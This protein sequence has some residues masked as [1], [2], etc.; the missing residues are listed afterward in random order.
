MSVSSWGMPVST[1]AL[2]FK[3][4]LKSSFAATSHLP[5]AVSGHGARY[6]EMTNQQ[7][8]QQ[9]DKVEVTRHNVHLKCIHV[10]TIRTGL[11][12]V[13]HDLQW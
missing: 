9:I 11:H 13:V 2:A 5:S 4:C 12:N 8:L 1:P 3:V 10:V 6:T 7:S